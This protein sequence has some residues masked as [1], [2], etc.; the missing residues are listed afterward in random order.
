MI[1]PNHNG[2]ATIGT[3]LHSLF[4]SR[5][6]PFEVIV[7]DDC[8]SDGS[9][10]IIRQFPCRLIRLD[11][12]SGASKARN[13]GAKESSGDALFF[14]DADCVVQEDTL[15]RVADAYLRNPHLIIGGSYTPV[16]HDDS[17]YSTFQSVCINYAELKKQTPDYVASHA[18]VIGR[19]IF[20]K[21]GGFPE[22]FMPILEDVE[23]SHR[24]KKA[25]VRLT[26]DSSILVRHIFNFTLKKSLRNAMKKSKYWT[27]YSLGNSDISQDSGTASYELKINVVSACMFWLLLLCFMLSGESF[28]L[29]CMLIVAIA[30]IIASRRLIQAFFRVKGRPFGIRATLYYCVIYPLP[31]IAG[32]VSGTLRYVQSRRTVS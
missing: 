8:S 9:I 2:S 17:F 16:A 32:G 25:G 29:L 18:M 12:H 14:I 27:G 5:Y 6:Q 20:E 1:I 11:P 30:N 28:F 19:G 15:A 4:S 26:M 7:V 24:V 13:T 31:V 23:F 10:D 21:S 22:D 3:C